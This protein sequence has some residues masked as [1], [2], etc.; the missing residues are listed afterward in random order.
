MRIWPWYVDNNAVAIVV[1]FTALV[2]TVV[3]A[4]FR[5]AS[6]SR[7]RLCRDIVM[8]G[9]HL[10]SALSVVGY[11]LLHA[12]FY[13]GDLM[14]CQISNSIQ[15]IGEFLRRMFSLSVYYL[16]L[17]ALIGPVYPTWVRYPALFPI[18]I[19]PIFLIWALDIELDTS[20][21]AYI[22]DKGACRDYHEKASSLLI[23]AGVCLAIFDAVP[24]VV[25]LT[26]FILPLL[27]YQDDSINSTIK[28]HI[29]IAALGI[30]IDML[31]VVLV[32]RYTGDFPYWCFRALLILYIGVIFSNIMLI[33][34]FADWR[35]Y[36]CMK[37]RCANLGKKSLFNEHKISL[38]AV[39]AEERLLS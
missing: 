15:Y 31:F 10:I 25:Y 16:R 27:K 29:G 13:P 6:I 20:L 17:D 1:A 4:I 32:F 9:L 34:V 3:L 35:K 30:V 28:K 14:Q 22:D 19:T 39:A 7:N 11:I 24:S 2:T 5:A 21:G 12:E 8:L 23:K 33:F 37:D 18:I 36:F 38:K 26:M